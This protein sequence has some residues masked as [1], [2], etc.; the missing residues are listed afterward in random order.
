MR[1]LQASYN[2]EP[3]PNAGEIS[4]QCNREFD[5]DQISSLHGKIIEKS[6][7]NKLQEN[8]GGTIN[9]CVKSPKLNDENLRNIAN[10]IWPQS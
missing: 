8:I 7:R 10:K 2:G 4:T 6:I 1:Q 5:N 9:L 3:K